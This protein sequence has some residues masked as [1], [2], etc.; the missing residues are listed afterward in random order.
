MRAVRGVW[1]SCNVFITKQDE[2]IEV[3]PFAEDD[4]TFRPKWPL[5]C[6]LL[7]NEDNGIFGVVEDNYE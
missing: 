2:E 1:E 5:K 6:F 7:L 3:Y 4:K